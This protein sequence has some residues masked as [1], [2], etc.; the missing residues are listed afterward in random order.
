MTNITRGQ[1][2]SP[3]Y[4]YNEDDT[5]A[6]RPTLSVPPEPV[7][8]AGDDLVVTA[9]ADTT[10]DD[11]QSAPAVSIAADQGNVAEGDVAGFTVSLDQE[12]AEDVVVNFTYSGETT[13]GDDFTAV[14]SVTIAAG[15]TSADLDLSTLKSDDMLQYEYARE[16]LK[17]G[18]KLEAKFGTNP[19]KFGMVGGIH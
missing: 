9:S 10:I 1:I 15:D 12:A 8:N 16:A 5:P 7:I 2:F 4:L 11:A 3:P 17:N 19:Y 13:A 18:L 14:A 6:T